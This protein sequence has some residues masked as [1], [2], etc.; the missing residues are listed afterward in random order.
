MSALSVLRGVIEH[1]RNLDQ[2]LAENTEFIAADNS[3]S[4][5]K[6]LVYGVLRHYFQLQALSNVLLTRPVKAKDR[7]LLLLIM[8]GLFQLRYHS[9]PEYAVVAETVNTAHVLGKPWAK[10]LL[11]AVLRNYLRQ[12]EK[13]LNAALQE[14]E[15]ARYNAPQWLITQL[16]EDW[17]QHWQA[18]LQA[19]A[20][21][22]PMVLRVNFA[23]VTRDDYLH[24]LAEA[25]MRGIP[26]DG[27]P[28]AIRLE[29]ACDVNKLPGFSSG[30]VSV[31]DGAA[32]WAALLLGAEAGER[33][34]D[35]C[36]APGGKTLHIL[37]CRPNPAELLALDIDEGRAARITDSLHRL[38]YQDAPF[39]LRIADAA[40]LEAWWDGRF[41]HRILLDAPCSGTGVIRRHPDIQLLK[42][43]T[44]IKALARQQAL[45]LRALWRTLAPGGVMIYCTCSILR[46][47]NNLQMQAFLHDTLDAEV[48]E[49]AIPESVPCGVGTQILTGSLER[50][51]FYYAKLG[52]R[53]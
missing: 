37:E 12:P 21:Q 13:A 20:V 46:A 6:A 47:E 8:M 24:R 43:P 35:A 28:A 4:L 2:S 38:G 53:G 40:D 30:W 33:V 19:N 52:K 7:D 36:A 16:Q 39:A 14:S 45:L 10:G 25:D 17:P 26:L 1:G 5:V 49:F 27:H 50:D 3:L 23:R 29:N 48:R 15:S 9:A 18:L 31:Q 22:A 34:L 32:Q 44:D 51:G 42:R 11:N 41:F